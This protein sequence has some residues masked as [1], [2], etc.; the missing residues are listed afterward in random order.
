LSF[1]SVIIF[2]DRLHWQGQVKRTQYPRPIGSSYF[3]ILHSAFPCSWPLVC[4][5]PR[6]FLCARPIPGSHSQDPLS[7]IAAPG[8]PFPVALPRIP[9]PGA[10]DPLP[11]IRSQD[12][13]PRNPFPGSRSQDPPPG[14]SYLDPLSQ[15]PLPRI[16][17]PRILGGTEA[18]TACAHFSLNGATRGFSRLWVRTTSVHYFGQTAIYTHTYSAISTRT[19][20]SACCQTMTIPWLK[21]F[22][23]RLLD[24]LHWFGWQCAR[25]QF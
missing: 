14:S 17:F 10:P 11:R 1:T 13:L 8:S 20:A 7:R 25:L 4:D 19:F 24:S 12:P 6:L 3:R 23:L 2:D 5:D 16:P 15:D 21:V 18:M 22:R 9:F